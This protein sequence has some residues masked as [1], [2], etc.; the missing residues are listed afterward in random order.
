[1]CPAEAPAAPPDK[2]TS[3]DVTAIGSSFPFV[4]REREVRAFVEDL[5]KLHLHHRTENTSADIDTPPP[6]SDFSE[7]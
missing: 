6:A 4:Q 7:M 5:R 2:F 3:D 1:M